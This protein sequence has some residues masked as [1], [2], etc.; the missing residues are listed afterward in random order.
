MNNQIVSDKDGWV[1]KPFGWEDTHGQYRIHYNTKPFDYVI[2]DQY[3][4]IIVMAGGL[5]SEGKLYPWVEDRLDVAIQL[6][7][8]HKC[9]I[10][11]TGGGT[12]HKPPLLN[13]EKYVIHEST[14][15]AEYLMT[16]HVNPEHVMKEWASYDTIASVYFSLL[17]CVQPQNK[18]RICVITSKFHMERTKQLFNWIFGLHGSYHFIFMEVSNDSIKDKD[19]LQERIKRE[20]QSVINV[21]KLKSKIKSKEDF[22][23]WLFTEHKAYACTFWNEKREPISEKGKDS[24]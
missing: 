10:L 13:Q 6:Y 22:H 3:D 24:Y 20:K 16:N 8:Q 7:Q 1:S 14:A 23:K 12:Y 9:N 21:E 19:M 11:C 18:K 4:L 2:D 17:L 15:C 5:N